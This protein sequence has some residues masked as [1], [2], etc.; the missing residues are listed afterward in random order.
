MFK[1]RVVHDQR[2][3]LS[4]LNTTISF[5]VKVTLRLTVCLDVEPF[6]VLMTRCLLLFVGYCR[7]FVG[8]SLWWE[9]G[10]AVCHSESAI[11]SRLS[12]SRVHTLYIRPLSV[13]GQYSNVC[14]T[15][16]CLHCVRNLESYMHISNRT[17]PFQK[18]VQIH[19]STFPQA[20]VGTSHMNDIRQTSVV[21]QRLVDSISAVVHKR[22]NKGTIAS[23]VY[24]PSTWEPP[25]FFFVI[26]LSMDTVALL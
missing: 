2:T 5:K 17:I 11:F 9:V 10:P 20:C 3:V 4:F 23:S 22:N 6:L 7:V 1:H 12:I 15:N 8:R 16:S 14:T 21:K 25:K 19:I 18:R 26:S 13:R 24:F